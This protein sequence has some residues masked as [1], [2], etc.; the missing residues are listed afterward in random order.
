MARHVLGRRCI[1]VVLPDGS[2]I[3]GYPLTIGQN[4]ALIQDGTWDV[5]SNPSSHPA[6]EVG[7]AGLKLTAA[8]F[9]KDVEWLVETFDEEQISELIRICFF[10]SLPKSSDPKAPA[11]R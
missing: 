6:E 10:E 8:V 5:F 4:R 9:R 2:E 7:N 3:V 1:E 11:S